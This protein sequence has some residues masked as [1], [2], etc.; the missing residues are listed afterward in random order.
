VTI[1]IM[2]SGLTAMMLCA[3]MVLS[4]SHAAARADEEL[5][6]ILARRI[7]ASAEREQHESYAGLAFAQATISPEPSITLPSSRTS[8]GT[9]RLP[10]SSCTSRRPRVRLSTPGSGAKP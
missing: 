8:V 3:L 7:G 5:D 9:Q 6:E 10:V 2:I 4:L 1:I